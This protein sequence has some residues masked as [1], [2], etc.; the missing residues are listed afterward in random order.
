MPANRNALIRYKTID[1]CL[2]NRFRK[3]TLED[4]IEFCS[5]ALYEYEGIDKGVSRRT[6]QMDIQMMRSEKLGYNAP[7]IVVDKKYYTYEDPEYSIT[8][9]PLTEQDLNKLT[10][11]VDILRQFKGFAHFQELSGMVQRLEDKIYT[12][13]SKT[14]AIIHLDKNESLRG[15]KYLEPIYQAI[16]QKESLQ[17]SYQSFRR[18]QPDSLVFFAYMLKEYRNRWYILG[19]KSGEK[20][21]LN[22]ALDRLEGVERSANSYEEY[23]GPDLS[24]YFDPV[25]GV[26]VNEGQAPDTVKLFAVHSMAP[27]LLTKPLHHSQ[28]VID[29]GS[30]GITLQLKVQ[31]N[32]E[33]EKEILSLSPFVKVLQ[34]E[35]LKRRIYQ[36]LQHGLDYYES[37][38][39]TEQLPKIIR[40]FVGKGYTHHKLFLLKEVEEIKKR[41]LYYFQTKPPQSHKSLRTIPNLLNAVP[42]LLDIF[43]ND[44]LAELLAHLLPETEL[45]TAHYSELAEESHEDWQPDHAFFPL[46]GNALPEQTI[47]VRLYLYND[48]HRKRPFHCVPGSQHQ[49]LREAPID[50]TEAAK[51]A[52]QIEAQAGDVFISHPLLLT[53]SPKARAGRKSGV[54]YLV[55]GSGNIE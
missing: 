33:L 24:K 36:R 35:S 10:E 34:P 26:T 21:L 1:N 23:D 14:P 41:L 46:T 7:I 18:R 49:A 39:T 45:L 44:N 54:V 29:R 12:S 47:L 38:L 31:R 20:R 4:L 19:R 55:F 51:R 48:N 52:Q 13:K 6:V 42:N 25:I 32:F 43:L 3:W 22:L 17:L 30:Q 5:E 11:V 40:R 28:K 50:P 27:Y 9:I 37:D 8:N 53:R 16:L 15:L 2:R